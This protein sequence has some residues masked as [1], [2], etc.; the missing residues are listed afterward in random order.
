MFKTW[1]YSMFSLCKTFCFFFTML[2]VLIFN[3]ITAWIMKN[4]NRVFAFS[5]SRNLN[6]LERELTICRYRKIVIAKSQI[7]TNDDRK[8]CWSERELRNNFLLVRVEY[9][10]NIKNASKK[11]FYS[12]SQFKLSFTKQRFV[13]LKQLFC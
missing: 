3:I 9:V 1:H 7:L 11:S 10:K 12:N 8:I 4:T 6:R 5:I 2:F 13:D